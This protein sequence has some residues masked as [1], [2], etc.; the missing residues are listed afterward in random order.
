[1]GNIITALPEISLS[2]NTLQDFQTSCLFF[3]SNSQNKLFS[4]SN[5]V[6]LCIF[7]GNK[8]EL[9]ELNFLKIQ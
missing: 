7:L 6:T 4:N 3:Q 1:M 2:L 8:G 9:F 5:Q